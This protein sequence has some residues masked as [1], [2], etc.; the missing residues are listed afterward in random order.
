MLSYIYWWLELFGNNF[1]VCFLLVYRALLSNGLGLLVVHWQ[2]KVYV[3][4]STLKGSAKQEPL[5]NTE[6]C[7]SLK[8]VSINLFNVA[9]TLVVRKFWSKVFEGHIVSQRK[10]FHVSCFNSAILHSSPSNIAHIPSR[11]QTFLYSLWFLLFSSPSAGYSE[12]TLHEKKG[13]KKTRINCVCVRVFWLWRA[14]FM[15]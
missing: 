3:Y 9:N 8:N 15:N 4:L 7:M 1:P 2:L 12:R 13:K 10:I 14:H 5:K 6:R 11:K